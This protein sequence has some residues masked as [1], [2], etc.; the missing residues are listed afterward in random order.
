MLGHILHLLYSRSRF[1]DLLS[2]VRATLDDEGGYFEV[3][4]S[5]HKGSRLAETKSMLLPVVAAARG[6]DNS[7]WAA[8]YLKL[9]EQALLPCPQEEPM[10]MLPA[11]SRKGAAGWS[12]RFLTSGEMNG[13]IKAFFEAVQHDLRGRNITTHSLKTTSISWC[14]KYGIS[15]VT[16]DQYWQDISTQFREQL[17]STLVTSLQQLFESSVAWFVAFTKPLSTRTRLGQGC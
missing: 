16:P 1:S 7:E 14:A 11:P 4:A 5:I 3:E 17:C 10:P 13:F 9:R 6:V 12:T 15:A 2:V 8:M